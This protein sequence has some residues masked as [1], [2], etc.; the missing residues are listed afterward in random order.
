MSNGRWACGAF[1]AKVLVPRQYREPAT[2]VRRFLS[3]SERAV[4]G[5]AYRVGLHRAV[6]A[7]KYPA[8]LPHRRHQGHCSPTQ[9]NAWARD[10][11]PAPRNNAAARAVLRLHQAVAPREVAP[12]VRRILL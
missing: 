12:E 9:T 7:R 5:Q 1:I 3:A 6:A 11:A 2:P 10:A 8:S 4:Q